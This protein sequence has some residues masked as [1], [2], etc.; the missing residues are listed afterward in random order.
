MI[1][2]QFFGRTAIPNFYP[3]HLEKIRRG[4]RRI[5]GL[6][7]LCLLKRA[8]N[9]RI[10]NPVIPLQSLHDHLFKELICP[11]GITE[12]SCPEGYRREGLSSNKT[13]YAPFNKAEQN[14]C[15]KILIGCVRS[16]EGLGRGEWLPSN[17]WTIKKGF[18]FQIYQTR[19]EAFATI[20]IYEKP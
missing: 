17:N 14:G 6:R 10:S 15:F 9:F 1:P 5:A 19:F 20:Y 13:I 18:Q 2:G 4:G 16:N 8:L 3:I 11:Q 7:S 12:N